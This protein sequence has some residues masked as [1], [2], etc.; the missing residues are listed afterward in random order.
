MK[1]LNL[2]P[3]ARLVAMVCALIFCMAVVAS[4]ASV[5]A[6][7]IAKIPVPVPT[8]VGDPPGQPSLPDPID[9]LKS[10][11]LDPAVT[12]SYTVTVADPLGTADTLVA[13][14]EGLKGWFTYRGNYSVSVRV[15][16]AKLKQ[17]TDRLGR[18]G[19]IVDRNVQSEGVV[20]QLDMQQVQLDSKRKLLQ[21]YFDILAQ[22]G[23]STVTRVE[24]EILNLVSEIEN[25][26]A[27]SR[28]LLHRSRF[29][30]VTVS[31]QIADRRPPSAPQGAFPWVDQL[32]VD[33]LMEDFD[34]AH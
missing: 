25:L 6:A 10:D 29:A 33:A 34:H 12:A 3:H 26:A 27:Q 13:W 9:T 15:P 24:N 21:S 32:G 16:T 22:S 17:F 31:F 8:Q 4:A 1:K 20:A 18:L 19:T 5:V 7:P 28:Q 23:P 11:T 14:A 30:E 2:V